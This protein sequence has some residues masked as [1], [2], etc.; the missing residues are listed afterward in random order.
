MMLL[1][2]CLDG[3]IQKSCINNKKA[4]MYRAMVDLTYLLYWKEQL[5]F[6]KIE[7]YFAIG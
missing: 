3:I 7:T 4:I 6:H 1:R 5:E 2:L